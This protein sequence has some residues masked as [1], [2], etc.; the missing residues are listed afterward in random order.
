MI[1]LGGNDITSVPLRCHVNGYS[2][3]PLNPRVDKT[4]MHVLQMLPEKDE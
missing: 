2:S 1:I 3:I 4:L